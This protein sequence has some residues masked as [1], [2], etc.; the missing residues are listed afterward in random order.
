MNSKHVELDC[1]QCNK[2]FK[3]LIT[4]YQAKLK[5]G[6]KK[7]FCSGACYETWRATRVISTA[8]CQ[9]G[10]QFSRKVSE[11]VPSGR[12]F[13][14][15]SCGV[16]YNSKGVCRNPKRERACSIC[17]AQ[18]F[19]TRENHSKYCV[20]CK[21][22]YGHRINHNNTLKETVSKRSLKDRHP[23]WKSAYVRT[24]CYSLNR[25]IK[26][27]PCQ[28]CG[29]ATH[30]ELCHIKPVSSFDETA[31]LNEVNHPDN[32]LVLCPN[33]H[34]EFDNGKILLGDVPKRI[35]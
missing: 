18:Y 26:D 24:A 15:R 12:T 27:S 30:T 7:V 10:K 20:N 13:C 16:S 28:F 9:C 6:Q 29:Y 11:I 17:A 5:H 33:H 8:C 22:Q 4:K 1:F 3:M 21:P 25:A 14:S 31:T 23:S 35:S 34:W 32:I 19:Y 2:N